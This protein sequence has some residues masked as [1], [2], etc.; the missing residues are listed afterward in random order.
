MAEHKFDYNVEMFCSS[1]SGAVERMLK[2]S[3]DND[4]LVD[5][6]VDLNNK[7]VHVDSTG[8]DYMPFV[9]KFNKASKWVY[10]AKVDDVEQAVPDVDA[11]KAAKA[12]TSN[13]GTPSAQTPA[14]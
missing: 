4:E 7:M 3:K 12:G 9:E 2:K 10:W 13:V 8:T 1:C 11:L 5:Y 14:S 6:S